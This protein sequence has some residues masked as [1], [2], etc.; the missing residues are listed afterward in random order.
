MRLFAT[1]LL[2]AMAAAF[3]LIREVAGAGAHPAW[4]FALAFTEAAMVGGLADWFAHGTGHG[5]GIEVHEAP[6][7]ARR[8]PQSAGAPDQQEEPLEVGMVFTIEPGVYIP[9]RG[10]I[11]IEDDVLVTPAGCELLTLVPRDLLTR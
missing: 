11:R 10:G 7:I 9:G 1:G 4:G 5:L 8:R 2:V 6:R 3:L